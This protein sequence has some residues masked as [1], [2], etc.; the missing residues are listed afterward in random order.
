MAPTSDER[1][2]LLQLY[3]ERIDAYVGV[4][5]EYGPRWR[6]WCRT[7]LSHGGSVVVPPGIPEPDLEV[8]LARAS[9]F[10]P[11]RRLVQG[12]DNDCHRNVAVLWIDGEIASIGTGYALSDDGLWRQHS[13]GLEADGVVV[14]TTFERR[15]YVG[16]VL[17]A[18]ASSMQFAGSN[19]S[20]YLREVLKQRGP[21]AKE[22]VDMIRELAAVAKVATG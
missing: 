21:R 22:L 6:S 8:L 19:A 4:D 18:R 3:L 20:D 17:P 1:E 10:G 15:S 2:R 7:L 13:W 12:D 5:A 16:I 9:A 11:A 14:E